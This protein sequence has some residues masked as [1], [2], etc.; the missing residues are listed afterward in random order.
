MGLSVSQSY[1]SYCYAG[2]QILVTGATGF[3]GRRLI[4]GL[5]DQNAQVRAL[6]RS[7]PQTAHFPGNVDYCR[8]ALED[9]ASLERACQGIGIVFHAAAYAH[10]WSDKSPAIRHL[11]R[12]VNAE[13]TRCLLQMAANAGVKRFVF[14]SSVKAMGAGGKNCVDETWL[15]PPETPY[16]L[17]KRKAEQYVIEFGRKYNMHTVNLRLPLV[18]GPGG[19]GNLEKMIKAIKRSLFPSLPDVGNKRSM[20]HVDDVVQAALAAGWRREANRQ[21]YIVTDGH[22]YSSREIYEMICHALGKPIPNWRVPYGI[23]SGL[24]AF[25]DVLGWMC[26]RRMI[27]DNEAL[28]KILG[29]ACYRCDKI[30]AELDY[31]PSVTLADA[32]PAMVRA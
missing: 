31:R 2:E 24:A 12:Q 5:I 21:T 8:G 20:V 17:A 4:Q 22:A 7:D 27:F 10:A 3:I 19:R 13:G 9:V 32:L 14:F 6:I 26:G 16:G 30:R 25:G 11:H 29:W 15:L 18:Y 23:L 1:P 28:D